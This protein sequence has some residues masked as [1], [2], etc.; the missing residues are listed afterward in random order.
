MPKKRT[1]VRNTKCH[2]SNIYIHIYIYIYIIFNKTFVKIVYLLA[3]FRI[4]KKKKS[5]LY[6]LI[7]NMQISYLKLRSQRNTYGESIDI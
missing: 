4:L 7:N 3:F 5:K 6:F 1:N 2:P